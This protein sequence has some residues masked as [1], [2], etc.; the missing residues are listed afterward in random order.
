MPPKQFAYRFSLPFPPFLI[1]FSKDLVVFWSPDRALIKLSIRRL[2][3]S[4]NLSP[5]FG[6]RE[7]RLV[8]QDSLDRIV[9]TSTATL[10]PFAQNS[11]DLFR[12]EEPEGI[13]TRRISPTVCH[14][15]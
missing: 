4:A 14:G 9:R 10:H 5:Q 12:R 3:E 11:I 6:S 15:A 1:T 2:L 13:T 7:A 8:L